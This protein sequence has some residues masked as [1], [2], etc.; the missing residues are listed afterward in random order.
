MTLETFKNAL[1]L[2]DESVQLGGGEPTLHANFWEILGLSLSI[3]DVWL[4][5]NGSKTETALRLCSMA[6]RGVI[7]CALS[8]DHWHDEIDYRV[9]EA[10]QDDM[11][12]ST[13]Q[14]DNGKRYYTNYGYRPKPR[15]GDA[16]LDSREIR[17]ISDDVAK[18]GRAIENELFHRNE[19][20]CP[21][22]MVRPN[23]DIHVCGCLD[24][25]CIGNVNGPDGFEVLEEYTGI[26]C[27]RE[28]VEVQI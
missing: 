1:S 12:R 5:T 21:G 22:P 8:M 16:D 25:P 7:G 10:F 11:E 3:G 17:D 24:A 18:R 15:Y 20:S 9:V 13:R 4:A 27:H 14:G 28:K 19:C 2:C 23:G 26:D 6:R